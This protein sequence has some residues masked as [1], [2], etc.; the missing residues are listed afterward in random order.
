MKLLPTFI[1]V[2]TSF[3]FAEDRPNFV[4]IMADDMGY[5]DSSVY[6]GWIKTPQ[7]DRMAAEGLKFTD[8]HS[9][10]VVCSPTRAGLLTG[11]YQQRAGVPGVINADPNKRAHHVGLQHSEITLAELLKEAGYTTAM[12]GKWHLGYDVKYNPTSQGFG[13]FRGF[14]SGNIDYISHYDR[15]TTYDWWEGKEQIKEEGYLTHLLTKHSV[16]FIEDNKEK[17]FCLYV[18][19]GAVHSPIQGPNDPPV[20]GPNKGRIDRPQAETV[21]EMMKALDE[22]IGAIL[23]KLNETGLAERTLVMFFSDNGGAKHCKNTPLRGRKGSVW[24]GGHRVPSIA[25]WP[26]KI[27]PGTVS[28]DLAI[29]LDVMP[30]MLDLA[31]VKVPENLKLDGVSLAPLMLEG[32]GLGQRQLFWNGIAMRDGPW[33]LITKMRGNPSRSPLLFNVAEDISEEQD[34]STE[35]P[36]RVAKMTQALEAWKKDV[37]NATPQPDV[38]EEPEKTKKN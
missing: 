19:H 11:R 31:G 38:P 10:G 20:R 8:F 30:T 23:D 28:H 2:L 21:K 13:R 26:G 33:K 24:E 25:W 4:I 29:T 36:E 12:F 27:K 18:P 5:G 22:N 1:L 17:P 16:K 37:A 34:I 15:M 35:H 14:V 32:K 9:S 3:I 7:M 6:D